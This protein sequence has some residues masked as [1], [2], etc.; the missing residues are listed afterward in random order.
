MRAAISA[1]NRV[2]DALEAAALAESPHDLLEEERVSL[3]ILEHERALRGGHTIAGGRRASTS[4]SALAPPSAPSSIAL[5]RGCRRPRSAGHRAGRAG[6][7]HDTTGTSR[8]ERPRYSIRSSS[9][10]PT[11]SSS[12]SSR[13]SMVE[14]PLVDLIEY[15][16][17]SPG[18]PCGDRRARPAGHRA[19]RAGRAHDQHRR[20]AERAGQVLDHVEQRLLR[21][22]D[23]LEDEDERLRVASCSAHAE[24][25]QLSSPA[26]ARV[27]GGAEHA[28]RDREQVGDRLALAAGAELLERL[29]RRGVV[30]DPGRGLDHRGERPVGRR[31]RRRGARG[32]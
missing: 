11:R 6:R 29:G 30:G 23:V 12:S 10:S 26:R 25:A 8:R 17:R 28:E 1:C 2:G 32:R 7:A 9:S 31:P 20:V 18:R 13:T 16:G 27:L 14:E 21:P 19:G 22:V 24:A 15:L 3:R 4:S 5:A